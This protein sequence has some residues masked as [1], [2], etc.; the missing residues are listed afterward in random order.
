MK[1]PT[2]VD[3]IGDILDKSDTLDATDVEFGDADNSNVTVPVVSSISG[4]VSYYAATITKT[5]FARINWSW[6]APLM[7]DEDGNIVNPSDP[8]V[9]DDMYLDPVVDYMFGVANNG[10]SPTSF[11]ST[12]GSTS[13][14][15]EEHPLGINVTITVY[16]V[17]KSGIAGPTSQY[18]ATVSRDTTPPGQP[19]TLTLSTAAGTV[20]A[21]YD[22]LMTGSLPQP[23]DYLFTEIYAGTANPPTTKVGETRGRGIVTFAA[24]P[25]TTVYVRSVSYDSSYNASAYSTVVSIVVKS[26]LDDT[27][28]TA[29]LNSRARIISSVTDPV[30]PGPVANGD[31]WFK[32]DATDN[33]KIIAFYKRISGVWIQDAFNAAQVIAAQSIIAGLLSADAV[34]ADNIKAGEIYS[35]LS[36]TGEL[37]ADAI[38]TGILD[39]L[40]TVTGILR[41]AESGSRVTLDY[42]GIT[43]FDSNDVPVIFINTNGESM[44]NGNVTAKTI[45]VLGTLQL[46]SPN[47]KMLPGSSIVMSSKITSPSNPPTVNNTYNTFSLLDSGGIAFVPA[48]VGRKS[49]GK[50]VSDRS[51]GSLTINN[52]DGTY[53]STFTIPSGSTGAAVVGNYA[54]SFINTASY[55]RVYRT[56]LTTGAN[57]YYDV[58]SNKPIVPAEGLIT[59]IGGSDSSTIIVTQ[60]GTG[61]SGGTYNFFEYSITNLT[62]DN[63]SLTYVKKAAIGT[64]S[65]G[66]AF[67]SN[68]DVA[69]DSFLIP[70][71]YGATGTR[72]SIAAYST[73]AADATKYFYCNGGSEIRGC[74]YY[75]GKIWACQETGITVYEASI[76]SDMS[77]AADFAYTYYDSVGTTH[78]S[79]ISKKIN[80]NFYNRA[81]VKISVPGWSPDT[82]TVDSVNQLRFYC[83]KA[84]GG[85]LYLQGT[86][87]NGYVN[88]SS[89][90]TSGTTPLGS[91]TFPVVGPAQITTDDGIVQINS[92]GRVLGKILQ[93]RAV[94]GTA[95]H[96]SDGTSMSANTW[97]GV[98]DFTV[99][100]T[101]CPGVTNTHRFDI[102]ENGY[103]DIDFY[104]K[105]ANFGS[106]Y[107]RAAHIILSTGAVLAS[108]A[109]N[110]TGWLAQ[111]VNA[112]GI[113]LTS[114][115]YVAFEVFS[116][117]STIFNPVAG[118]PDAGLA[119]SYYQIRKVGN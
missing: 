78:E 98:V 38:S 105:W 103:Y 70:L 27:D 24:T 52:A 43:L 111:T 37:K 57:A 36:L 20:S 89:I 61:V 114:G 49:D 87:A 95:G 59:R 22:G 117:V 48:A 17:T 108:E 92:D 115:Q 64:N 68:L 23:D 29:A 119:Q 100:A 1:N 40:V 41:T 28:L 5:P 109:S 73:V 53:G 91:S 63:F 51:D 80:S 113:Y 85:T 54:Y 39:A 118:T 55:F 45:V 11:R 112:R 71:K 72:F 21:I 77:Q 16:A 56:N 102:T 34:V 65:Y 47:N 94:K 14:V 25:G 30:T 76:I 31:W 62:G 13:V 8:D 79:A 104:A 12:N 84:S 60:R 7:Y 106:A 86:N 19:S 96:T 81:I 9:A 88:L 50:F 58:T 74:G 83:A 6:V 18:T 10:A 101:N 99:T 46:N 97:T 33:T 42:T 66:P 116:G 44:F 3:V 82:S 75:S 26:I 35:K 90:A 93:S 2:L 15:T 4:T 69:A 110:G 67:R 107:N 32:L